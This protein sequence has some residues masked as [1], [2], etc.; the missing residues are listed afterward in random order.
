[1]QFDE[2]KPLGYWTRKH[3]ANDPRWTKHYEPASLTSMLN[4]G[5]VPPLAHA[6]RVNG[7]L[8]YNE[9]EVDAWLDKLDAWVAGQPARRAELEAE[10]QA[11][12]RVA[13]EQQMA[14]I[15]REQQQMREFQQAQE[16]FLADR[17]AHEAADRAAWER[18]NGRR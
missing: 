12:R 13:Q 4:Q 16:Q 6:G 5:L 9:G 17:E 7:Q 11:R 2:P 1:M 14:Q 18:A 8:L 10:R 15:R 3:I